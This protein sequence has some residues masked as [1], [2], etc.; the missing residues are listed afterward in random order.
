MHTSRVRW[1]QRLMLGY[2]SPTISDIIKPSVLN[3]LVNQYFCYLDIKR[4]YVGKTPFCIKTNTIYLCKFLKSWHHFTQ[5]FKQYVTLVSD[6]C[7]NCNNH[8]NRQSTWCRWTH[9]FHSGSTWRESG[10]R[11]IKQSLSKGWVA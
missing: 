8:N 3:L 11:K 9:F 5:F 1:T 6:I 4:S 10:E 2:L 7:N